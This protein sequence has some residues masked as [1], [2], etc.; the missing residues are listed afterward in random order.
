MEQACLDP[1]EEIFRT[2]AWRV[3]PWAYFS[4]SHASV[5]R[6]ALCH[7]GLFDERFVGW[8]FEDTELAYRLDEIGM[9][10]RPFLAPVPVHLEDSAWDMTAV[11][12]PLDLPP[13]K[14]AG[15]LRNREYFLGKYDDDP[16]LSRILR[17]TAVTQARARARVLGSTE[18]MEIVTPEF[19]LWTAYRPEDEL[20][21]LPPLP[22][23]LT[24]TAAPSMMED[25]E[26]YLGR[27]I[28]REGRFRLR[29][30]GWVVTVLA[31]PVVLLA[32][33]GVLLALVF[34]GRYAR[35]VRRSP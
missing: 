25:L 1:R 2:S 9:V 13:Q 5:R 12:D 30:P 16:E 34:S 22:E 28:R 33:V 17:T 23:A 14:L 31:T 29:L 21:T 20:A 8:G 32:C 35:I 3:T 10:F 26:H 6:S 27:P 4:A 18:P 19:S 11:D 15:F 7:A 24:D